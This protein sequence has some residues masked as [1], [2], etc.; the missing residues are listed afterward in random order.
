MR[1]HLGACARLQTGC[2][3]CGT[4]ATLINVVLQVCRLGSC[5]LAFAAPLAMI[6]SNRFLAIKI[7][8]TTQFSSAASLSARWGGCLPPKKPFYIIIA[9]GLSRGVLRHPV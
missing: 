8:T 9:C 3:R 4:C 7:L 1:D 2:R 6:V 5:S